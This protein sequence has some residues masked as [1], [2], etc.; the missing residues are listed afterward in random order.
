[1]KII[2]SRI[3]KILIVTLFIG[4]LLGIISFLM[5]KNKNIK[6]NYINYIDLINNG[7]FN[8]TNSLIKSIFYNLRY[9]FFIWI[10]GILFIFSFISLF[11]IAFKGISLGFMIT[12]IIW[13][14]KIKGVLYALILSLNS[15]INITIFL[16]LSYYSINFSIK[17][18]NA[19]R[20]NRQI[21]YKSFF[22][23]YIYI[24]VILSF[25]LILSSLFEIYI[26]SN[27][28]RFVV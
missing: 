21:N 1:M 18:L 26:C 25:S 10:F 27:I 15:I 3:L 16:L 20:N 17:S 5:I 6:F 13:T 28:I 9:S 7:N 8:Y 4:F 22:I 23:N 11:L 24:Y 14:F 2:K 12:S 19:Y